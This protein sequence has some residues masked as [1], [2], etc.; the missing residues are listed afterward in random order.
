MIIITGASSGLGLHIAKLYKESGKT[1]V[2]ISRTPSKH[3]DINICVSLAEEPG[4][5]TATKQILAMDEKIEA[6]INV[7]GVWSAQPFGDLTYKEIK[8]VMAINSDG[9]MFLTTKLIKKIRL[10]EAD[11]L[12]VIS[13]AGTVGNKNFGLY[14]ASKWAQRGFT[15]S[16]QDG[17]KDSKTRVI[18]FCPAGMNTQLF[19]KSGNKDLNTSKWMQPQDVAGLGK[20]ILDLPKAIEVSEIVLNKKA[21]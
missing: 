9:L 13:L 18:S 10:D 4:I 7:A 11:I 12:N 17:F 15:K 14:S 2:N 19:A 3:A 5:I 6:F 16:L 20:T 8:K 21:L 1:V